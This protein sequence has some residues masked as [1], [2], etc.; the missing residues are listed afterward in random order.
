MLEC[1]PMFFYNFLF[2]VIFD[3]IIILFEKY[4]NLHG[5]YSGFTVSSRIENDEPVRTRL[6][7]K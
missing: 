2:V 3:Y 5:L 1:A 4:V 6:R 7:E